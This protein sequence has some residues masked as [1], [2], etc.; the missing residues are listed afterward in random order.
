MSRNSPS[1][2]PS[3]SLAESTNSAYTP[4]DSLHPGVYQ[5]VNNAEANQAF[6]L[7]GYDKKG[8]LGTRPVFSK[9]TGLPSV[10]DEKHILATKAPIKRSAVP[11][12]ESITDYFKL[13]S[14]WELERLGPG[15]TIR[16]LYNGAYI[17]LESGIA[18]GAT[19]IGTPYPVSWAVEPD[20]WEAG[21]YRYCGTV[22]LNRHIILTGKI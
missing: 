14:Q 12:P 19:I 5:I 8:I 3:E 17:T 15:Y 11:R 10:M 9:L 1:P 2:A 22:E 13:K 18:S 7:S 4:G 20:D 21:I 16:S 6:D